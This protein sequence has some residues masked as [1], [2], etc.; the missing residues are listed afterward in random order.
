MAA[1]IGSSDPEYDEGGMG[2]GWMDKK[3]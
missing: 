1:G 3:N 2:N